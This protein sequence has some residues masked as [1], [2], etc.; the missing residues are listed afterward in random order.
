M[1]DFPEMTSQLRDHADVP[2]QTLRRNRSARA[3]S[4]RRSQPGYCVK[5]ETSLAILGIERCDAAANWS[6]LNLS[7]LIN[8]RYPLQ[9]INDTVHARRGHP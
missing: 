1:L 2:P 4:H 3:M 9:R 7:P 6:A 8:Q 5:R